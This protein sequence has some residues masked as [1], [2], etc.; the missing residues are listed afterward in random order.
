MVIKELYV[1]K[2]AYFP[3]RGQIIHVYNVRVLH[4]TAAFINAKTT[5]YHLLL[6][7]FKLTY[8]RCTAG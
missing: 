6:R 4:I 7:P 2:D 3:N 5:S 1:H 8:Q